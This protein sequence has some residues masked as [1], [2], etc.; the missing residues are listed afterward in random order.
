[1]RDWYPFKP[2]QWKEQGR[3]IIRIQNLNNSN[4]AFNRC[5]DH[6]PDKYLV[7]NGALLFAWSGTPGTSF[8]AHIWSGETGW[9]N[10]H[11]FRVDFDDGQLD[12]KFLRLA[13]NINLQDYIEQA[14]G[15]VGLAHVTKTKF[16]AS[17][18]RLPPLAEQQRIVAK[19]EEILAHVNSADAR[20]TKVPAVLKRF[21]RAVLVAACSGRLTAEWREAQKHI[22]PVETLYERIQTLRAERHKKE[23]ATAI[24][25]GRRK[26]ND[27]RN[28]EKADKPVIELP[29]LPSEWGLYTLQ[30]LSYLITDGTHKTP[31]YRERGVAFLSV[32][33]VRPFK[34]LDA[35]VKR[36]S[37]EEHEEINGRCNPE[38][39]DILYTK[40]GTFGY[41]AVNRLSYPFSLFVSVALIKPV[42]E[43][44]TPEY[45]G[46]VLNSD[47]VY[48]QAVDRVSGSG[49]P[50]L[51]L[52]EIRDFRIPLPSVEEQNEIVRR[53]RTLFQ[54]ADAVDLRLAE[55]IRRVDKL[56]QS[57][58]AKAFRGE[59]VPTEAELARREGREYE[60]ASVLLERIRRTRAEATDSSAKPRRKSRKVSAHV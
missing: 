44:F 48:A 53:V 13:I 27:P 18:L 45:A 23:T 29:E 52:L 50:D 14:H 2:S 55:T 58:L 16:D 51:H 28:S 12:K 24:R 39:G 1:V 59:L 33:N 32:K 9:L 42:Q 31:K 57:I 40:V 49:V 10:Q 36:I 8:G 11:I 19:V 15:G 20:L 5:P 22:E 41:A 6:I 3:P 30:D 34:I 25:E 35:D 26:P 43:C 7:Q 46:I 60:P 47:F 54:L 4:A 56:T 38:V 21:R 17:S 37:Q